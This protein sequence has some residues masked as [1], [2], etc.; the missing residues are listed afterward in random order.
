MPTPSIG[1]IVL[2]VL[3]KVDVEAIRFRR[4]HGSVLQQDV[5]SPKVGYVP[6]S[7]AGFQIHSGNPVEVGTV[8][9]MVITSVWGSG[10]GETVN[11]QVFLDGTDSYWATSRACDPEK[12]PGTWHWP[13]VNP[14]KAS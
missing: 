6:K 3:S 11:G 4:D 9:P 14:P 13:A 1:R 10:A 8:C 7:Y 12:A 5:N 2:Y